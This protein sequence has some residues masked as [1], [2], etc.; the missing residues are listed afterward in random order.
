VP[1]GRGVLPIRP[2]RV[3]WSQQA[4]VGPR[5]PPIGSVSGFVEPPYGSLVGSGRKSRGGNKRLAKGGFGVLDVLGLLAAPKIFGKGGC[6]NCLRAGCLSCGKGG[7]I[8]E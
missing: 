8:H 1:T 6:Q 4:S 3:S 2:L 7:C 5:P